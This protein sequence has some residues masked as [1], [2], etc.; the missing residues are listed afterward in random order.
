[1]NPGRKARFS[2]LIRFLYVLYV[3]ASPIYVVRALLIVLRLWRLRRIS[4][5]GYLNCPHCGNTNE[6]DILA[7]CPR[8]HTM[9][10]GSRLRCSGCGLRS[11]SFPC[12]ACGVT[13]R[14]L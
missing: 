13:I 4:M 11:T 6:L 8:C 1:M 7:L 5:R 9:E 12:D 2:C 14:A 3:L 10:Y